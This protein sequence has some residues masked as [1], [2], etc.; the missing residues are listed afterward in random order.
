MAISPRIFRVHGSDYYSDEP[1]LSSST[2][3]DARLNDVAAMGYDGV[4]LHAELRELAPTSLFRAHV[5]DQANRLESLQTTARRARQHGLGLWLY[6]NEPRGYPR[7]HPFWQERPECRGQEGKDTAIAWRRGKEW[8]QTYAMCLSSE[9]VRC[10]LREATRD[11]FQAVP[12]LAGAFVITASEHHTHCYSHLYRIRSG[13]LDCPRCRDRSPMEMP[14]EV[15]RAMQAGL[16]EAGS[17]ARLAFWTWSWRTYAP[18]PQQPTLDGLPQRIALLSDFERGETVRRLGKEMMVDEYSFAVTGPS[19]QFREYR[20]AIRP[21]NRE[22]WAKLQVNSTHELATVPNMPLPG[23]LY[24]KVRAARAIGVSGVLATWS[25]AVRPTLNSHAAGRLL[26]MT[27]ELPARE[28]FLRRLARDYFDA[29][30]SDRDVAWILEAWAHFERAI[31]SYPTT[32]EHVY[33]SPVNY[34]PAYPWKLKRDRSPMARSWTN[35]PWGDHLEMAAG[36]FTLGEIAQLLGE[37]AAQWLKG[38]P[39][40]RKALEPLAPRQKRAREELDT[41]EAC[42]LFFESCAHCF[43]FADAVD[44]RQPVSELQAWIARE[45]ATCDRLLPFLRRDERIG[46]HDEIQGRMADPARVEAKMAGLRE[47]RAT[48]ERETG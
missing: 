18:N 37:V 46:W 25:M 34:A 3:T 12:E 21:A 44:R 7:S 13:K 43:G 39:V 27:G 32:M 4:W 2:H 11:L 10:F 24:D 15:A 29:A 47:L 1:M 26:A 40:Y 5:R 38:I 30:L 23:I 16:D 33:F 45:L 48:L 8:F 36:A 17:N 22:I 20:E 14:V 31:Q 42:G 19:Q 28:D 9:T 41:A 35:E 6:L